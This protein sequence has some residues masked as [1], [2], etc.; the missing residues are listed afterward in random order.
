M[1]ELEF[2]V[3]NEPTP[4]LRSL[5]EEFQATHR[6]HVHF[7]VMDWDTAW[8][9]L[10][11][12]ALHGTG[13][14]VSVVGSTWGSTLA[15][16]N[17]LRP[18]TPREVAALGGATAFLPALWQSATPVN[19]LDV[20]TVPWTAYTYLIAYRRDLLHQ[21]GL[22]EAAALCSAAALHQTLQRL[23]TVEL[24]LPWIVPT[25]VPPVEFVHLTASWIWGAGGDIVDARGRRVLFDQPPALAGL[26]A[27]FE[28]YRHLPPAARQ[29]TGDRASLAIE[30]IAQERTA[31][32]IVGTEAVPTILGES[33]LSPT[34]RANLGYAALPGVPWVGGNNLVIWRHTQASLERERAAVALVTFLTSRPAQ[35]AYCDAG[36]FLPARRD[37]LAN[38]P[39]AAAPIATVI[40]QILETGRPYVSIS[41][42]SIVEHQ[43]GTALARLAADLL[44]DPTA[45]V[46]AL[47]RRVLDP[48]AQRLNVTLGS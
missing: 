4:K 39:F 19:E 16:M 42:W 41:L 44:A 48:L 32:M 28:L 3:I 22:D 20:W 15:S 17:A 21:A 45:D 26:R 1:L 23:Q 18:F 5:V 25:V 33:S 2:S 10:V 40:R 29:L 6:V 24:E 38:L 35:I 30:L 12:M 7:R 8:P 13:P 47:L 43:L 34:V 11:T 46:T 31:L 14:D 9:E 36:E 37:A 27:F